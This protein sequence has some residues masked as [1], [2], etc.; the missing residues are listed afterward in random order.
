MSS[1]HCPSW[2][3]C[4]TLALKTKPLQPRF[5]LHFFARRCLWRAVSRG[6]CSNKSVLPH[7][8]FPV[9]CQRTLTHFE[10]PSCIL[11]GLQAVKRGHW[12]PAVKRND[13]TRSA[14]VALAALRNM[15]EAGRDSRK[16]E[17]RSKRHVPQYPVLNITKIRNVN[18][19][20]HHRQNREIKSRKYED[21]LTRTANK[22]GNGDKLLDQFSC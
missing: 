16:V 4:R 12:N 10:G 22:A 6:P 8:L 18:Y 13:F 21:V 20:Y 3:S 17:E 7:C 5:V 15:R 11:E 14:A 9:A 1:I 2:R 19:W